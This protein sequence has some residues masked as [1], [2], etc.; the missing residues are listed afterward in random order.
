V[1]DGLIMLQDKIQNQRHGIGNKAQLP[2]R[3]GYR[4]LASK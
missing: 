4:D 1:L 3:P 2:E